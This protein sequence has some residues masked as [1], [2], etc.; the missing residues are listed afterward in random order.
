MTREELI[1]GAIAE[2]QYQNEID[3]LYHH[4]ILGM[5]WGVRRYQNEDG[6]LTPAGE[7]H[8]AKADKI[9]E[10]DKAKYG[11]KD[12]RGSIKK[13]YRDFYTKKNLSRSYKDALTLGGYSK[14][15]REALASGQTLGTAKTM[16]DHSVSNYIKAAAISFGVLNLAAAGVGTLNDPA[17]KA[18][19]QAHF[20]EW[21]NEHSNK[22]TAAGAVFEGVAKGSGYAYGKAKSFVDDFVEQQARKK[23][24]KDFVKTTGYTK[25]DIA[26]YLPGAT[27]NHS[28]N[29]SRLDKG[30]AKYN[31]KAKN[32][33]DAVDNLNNIAK[34]FKQ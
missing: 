33:M 19:A 29:K 3:E 27:S 2:L 25:Y 10:K 6:S 11:F 14:K 8:Y 22:R 21:Y 9:Y 13:N 1:H 34:K 12:A 20:R 4:G 15:T 18:R 23:A 30:F 26:G 7:K 28:S 16:S 31:R 32:V 24:T 5:K 17:V